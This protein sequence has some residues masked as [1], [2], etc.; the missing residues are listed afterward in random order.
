[1]AILFFI[2]ILILSAILGFIVLIQNPKGGGLSGNVGGFGNQVMGVKQTTDALEKGT[3][4]FAGII[5][6]L[7]IISVT[8]F[9]GSSS[10][11]PNLLNNVNTNTP[12]QQAP[13]SA[14]PVT[15]QPQ[16]APETPP[17]K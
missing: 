7:C 4:L 9:R 17:A 15:D 10:A 13:P 6:F 2:L 1:M 14:I 3:W 16:Q 5:G 8:L 12:V 11:G